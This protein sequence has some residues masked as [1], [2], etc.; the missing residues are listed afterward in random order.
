LNDTTPKQSKIVLLFIV[1][2]SS[3]C[4]LQTGP[5]SFSF[6][7]DDTEMQTMYNLLFSAQPN[8]RRDGDLSAE[9][10]LFS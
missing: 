2:M 4:T 5:S 1:L 3:I 9:E 7:A 8:A 6:V 10:I